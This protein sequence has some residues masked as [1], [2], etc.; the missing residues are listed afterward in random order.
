[1]NLGSVA[2]AA[3]LASIFCS[4]APVRA[5]GDPLA[6]LAEKFVAESELR[7]PLFAD[8]IGVHT[9]DD[10]LAD[11][12]A[13]GQHERIAWLTSSR[14]RIAAVAAGL[15]DQLSQ[16]DAQALLDTIDLELFEDRTLQPWQTDPSIYTDSIGNAV[17]L[18]TSRTYAPEAERLRHVATRL[19]LIPALAAAA[20][21]N[22]TRPTRAAALQA[23][24]ANAGNI[25][26]YAELPKTREIRANLPAALAALRSFQSFLKGP[27]LARADRS[28]RVGATVYDRELQLAEGTDVTRAE[29]VARARRDFDA[30]RE[31]MLQLA[32]PLDREMFPDAVSDETKPNAIDVVVPR[33]LEKLA[34]DH[35]T[36]D[37][38]FATAKADVA[39][40]EDFLTAHPVVVLPEPS[41]LSVVPTPP[42]LAGFA[43]ASFD[44]PGPF[45]PLA[46]S[47]YLIDEIPKAWTDAQVRSYLR[48]FNSYEMK[49]LSMHE[50]VPGHYVQFRYNNATPSLVRRVF[51][52]G[53]YVEGWAVYTEGMML[54]SGYGG[55]DP[56]LRLFQLKWRLRE[57]SN[58]LIDA[59]FHAGGM[60]KADIEDLLVRQAF[61]NQAQFSNKWHRLQISH[62]QLSSYYVGLDTITRAREAVRAKLGSAYDLAA[63]NQA[64]LR[65]G[66]VEPR[67]IA[68]LV[69]RELGMTL[70]GVP[71][72]R[73][74]F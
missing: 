60:T 35:P 36:R 46:E 6:A 30:T 13:G 43:G 22:L 47:F 69:A 45:A 33:V 15:T 11:Y 37:A 64:L 29:L 19:K 68:P 66:S 38:V 71:G 70:P 65:I 63:F 9:Y 67:Y 61:Q 5:A 42:F 54:D 16:A 62:N 57:Q 53:S 4:I 31:R 52:N 7:D 10:R 72:E 20:K 74:R 49:M 21:A 18:I 58:T 24:D 12:S 59:G 50:A 34:D 25:E 3:A 39:A 8:G 51:G 2:L 32:L 41:T 40:A 23:I 44:G 27:L 48:D 28:P 1:M 56:K 14:A 26:M 55:D 17:Y 73:D